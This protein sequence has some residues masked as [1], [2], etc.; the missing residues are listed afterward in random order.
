MEHV[1]P[2]ARPNATGSC[3]CAG[4]TRT[5]LQQVRS[6]NNWEKAQHIGA[7]LAEVVIKREVLYAAT[8]PS[9]WPAASGD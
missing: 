8:S 1:G 7:P 4:S 6:I 3:F 9:P 2:A 5:M